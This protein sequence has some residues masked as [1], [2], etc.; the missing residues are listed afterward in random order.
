MKNR[1]IKWSSRIGFIMTAAG[2]AVGLGNLQRFPH[3]VI[4]H[5]GGAF[6]LLYLACVVVFALPLMLAEFS[7]GRAMKSNA[8]EI[9]SLAAPKKSYWRFVGI[10]S[11]FVAFCI[12]GYYVISCSWTLT[13]VLKNALKAGSGTSYNSI[14][15]DPASVFIYLVAF[16]IF[17]IVITI[18]GLNQ[19]VEKFSKIVMPMMFILQIILIVKILSIKGSWQGVLAYLKPDFTKLHKTSLLYALSQAFF[20]LCVGEAVLTTYGSYASKSESLPMSAIYIAILDTLVAF[21][22]GLIIFPAAYIT[23]QDPSQGQSLIYNALFPIFNKMQGG[24]FFLISYFSILLIAGLTTCISLLDVVCNSFCYFAKI[25]KKKGIMI[26]GFFAFLLGLPSLYS[27]GKSEFLTNITFLGQK[28]FLNIID[29]VA[30]SLGMVICS[31]FTT[32]FVGWIWGAKKASKELSI[33]APIFNKL[34]SLWEIH[35]KWTA[36]IIIVYILKTIVS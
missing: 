30:G 3:L 28:G 11:V 21:L 25:S 2:A 6:L 15:Q 13:Y 35:I 8:I 33:N 27:G 12:L 20:S 1:K 19:G 18:K 36:P 31:L 16:Y 23:S 9:F 32:I 22:A 24:S 29:L 10:F 5:G 4:T 7:L 26:I 17:I 34:K 14:M